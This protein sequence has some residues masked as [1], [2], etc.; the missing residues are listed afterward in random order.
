MCVGY[1]LIFIDALGT[2]SVD[3]VIVGACDSDGSD[4]RRLCLRMVELANWNVGGREHPYLQPLWRR[5]SKVLN[6]PEEC[7][8]K[9][10][11]KSGA[12]PPSVV[13]SRNIAS[14]KR[15]TRDPGSDGYIDTT[16][17]NSPADDYKEKRIVGCISVQSEDLFEKS[18]NSSWN[19]IPEPA[20]SFERVPVKTSSG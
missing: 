7:R 17:S 16:L 12:A 3:M 20:E 13:L 6:L 11:E 10:I 9:T 4:K 5:Q 18:A 2:W 15:S 8:S 1:H 14:L 19:Q